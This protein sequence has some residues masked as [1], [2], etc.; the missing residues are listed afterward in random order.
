MKLSAE[1]KKYFRKIG[2]PVRTRTVAV[3][4]PFVQ[5]W[6]EAHYGSGGLGDLR[7]FQEF[8]LNLRQN[9]L[10]IIYGNNSPL[11]ENGIAGNVQKHSLSVTQ[12][13]WYDLMFRIGEGGGGEDNFE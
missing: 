5:V 7:Y 10:R 13:E 1:I 12:K 8:P 9:L 6:I 3:K 4:N 11:A 2:I